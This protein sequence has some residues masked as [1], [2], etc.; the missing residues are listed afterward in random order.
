MPGTELH[1]TGGGTELEAL[2]QPASTGRAGDVVGNSEES[3]SLWEAHVKIPC[4]LQENAFKTTTTTACGPSLCQKKKQGGPRG[5]GTS[6]GPEEDVGQ[7]LPGLLG[8]E[9]TVLPRNP[10][11][12]PCPSPSAMQNYPGM[13]DIK[14]KRKSF[15]SMPKTYIKNNSWSD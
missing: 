13:L 3:D 12:T 1:T 4:E 14:R 7:S 5:A 8:R 2:Q 11:W 15:A 9:A 6:W 10:G